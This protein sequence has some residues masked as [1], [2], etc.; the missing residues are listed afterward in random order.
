M[1]HLLVDDLPDDLHERL[2]QHSLKYHVSM[3]GF[4]HRAL[5]RELQRVEEL[6]RCG[7]L[8]EYYCVGDSAEGIREERRLRDEHLDRVHREAAQP[9]SA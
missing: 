5:E 3:S 9:R 2:E 4:V 6:E 8:S 7:E 1:K